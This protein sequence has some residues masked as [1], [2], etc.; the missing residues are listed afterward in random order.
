MSRQIEIAPDE[1][2]HIYNRG[3]HQHAI[4]HD[5]HDYARFLFLIL[6]FQSPLSFENIGRHIS[7][8]MKQADFKVSAKIIADVVHQ[9]N[10]ELMAFVLMPNHFHVIVKEIRVNGISDYMHRIGT[11]FTNYVNIKY[12][13]S[14]H[15]FQGSY[16]AVHISDNDQLLY[17]SAYVHKNARTLKSWS[18][19]LTQY[20]WSSYQDFV[21]D[22]RWENLIKRDLILEQFTNAREYQQWVKENPA[23]ELEHLD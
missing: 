10:V 19:K 7:A 18:N 17:T 4:F 22:N 6:F 5:K 13:H 12:H 3:M 11:A 9:R 8:F 2:Y 15:I 20:P 14:G 16:R 1:I 21:E 23:K